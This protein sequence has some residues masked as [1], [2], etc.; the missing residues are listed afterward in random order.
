MA[1][2]DA[3]KVITLAECVG[4]IC[5]L[6]VKE[7]EGEKN[8][9][10]YHSGSRVLLLYDFRVSAVPAREHAARASAVQAR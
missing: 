3:D 5:G 8:S 6:F 7:E 2:S 10:S 4:R 9:N 1:E